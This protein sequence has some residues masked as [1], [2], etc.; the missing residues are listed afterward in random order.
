[1]GRPIARTVRCLKCGGELFEPGHAGDISIEF[2]SADGPQS[3]A[4][5]CLKCMACG[6]VFTLAGKGGDSEWRQG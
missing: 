2:A 6:A 3:Y 4:L 5:V 1:M